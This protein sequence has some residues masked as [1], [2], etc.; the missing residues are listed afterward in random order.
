MAQNKHTSKVHYTRFFSDITMHY[1]EPFI[2]PLFHSLSA[3]GTFT[4]Y[5]H[6][7]CSSGGPS[8]AWPSFPRNA[9]V[10]SFISFSYRGEATARCTRDR[11]LQNLHLNRF[12]CRKKVWSDSE[13]KQV[14]PSFRCEVRHAF[15]SRLKHK[16][17]L[18]PGRRKGEWRRG[19]GRRCFFSTSEE[20]EDKKQMSTCTHI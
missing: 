19:R 16:G 15:V 5:F 9:N 6:F 4:Y 13:V 3:Q 18:I 7:A 10:F 11:G 2:P 8:H 17:I 12:R 1:P 14:P 20:S